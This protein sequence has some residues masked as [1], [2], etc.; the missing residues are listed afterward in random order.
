MSWQPARKPVC[1]MPEDLQSVETVIEPL[2][3]D[4]GDFEV[5]RVLP[6]TKRR[7]VGPFVFFDQMGPIEFGADQAIDVRPHPHIGLST[8]T[9]LLQGEILHR[10]SLGY[11]QAIRP[12]EVN[13]M[14]AGSGIAHSE[15]SPESERRPGAK[16]FGIQAWTALPKHYEE[17]EPSFTHYA[18][19]SIPKVEGDGIDLRLIA[20]AAWGA[21][22]PVETLWDTFYADVTIAADAELELP[23]HVEERALYV[24]TGSLEIAGSHFGAGRM[25]V[26]RSGGT[27]V[28]RAVTDT[29]LMVLG[30]APMDGPRHIWWN[31]VSSS[32]E[33]IEQ[34]KNDWRNGHFGPVEGDGDFIPLPER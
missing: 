30:G 10:D 15:R 11:V 6:S 33:R 25:A 21:H 18:A 32:R 17:I 16:L 22:S 26:L 23:R 13:W 14:T 5:R 9:W 3:R 8:I 24:L 2:A 7:M 19:D 12:G 1:D 31:F 29:R 20:G 28:L 27:P 4:I 34:A